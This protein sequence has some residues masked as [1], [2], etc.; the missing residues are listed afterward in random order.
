MKNRSSV[1]TCLEA[2]KARIKGAA[3]DEGS[4]TGDKRHHMVRKS[5][6]GPELSVTRICTPNNEHTASRN[7]LIPS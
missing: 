5:T 3:T 2:R 7:V 1:D 4:Q 6:V